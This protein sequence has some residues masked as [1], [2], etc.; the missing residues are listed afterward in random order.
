MILIFE[1]GSMNR[2]HLRCYS[3]DNLMLFYLE[4]FVGEGGQLAET[5]VPV[6]IADGADFRRDGA[7][8][9]AG[10][11]FLDHCC[12]EFGMSVI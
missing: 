5:L 12:V 2:L 6:G 8:S 3:P 11:W 4:G 7:M 1:S 9:P 10:E